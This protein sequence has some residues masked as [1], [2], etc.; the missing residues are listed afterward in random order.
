MFSKKTLH[1]FINKIEHSDC[2]SVSVAQPFLKV[3]R[4]LLDLRVHD[5]EVQK[6]AGSL[7]PTKKGSQEVNLSRMQRKVC[8]S[9]LIL[10][11]H[12]REAKS[13]VKQL[14][15]VRPSACTDR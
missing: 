14:V 11:P 15:N 5:M 12:A 3:M 13:K 9:T 10:L 7:A 2:L 4:V 6:D 8:N 1:M